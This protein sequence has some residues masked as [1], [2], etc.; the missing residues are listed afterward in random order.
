MDKRADLSLAGQ[1]GINTRLSKMTAEQRQ[2]MT[3]A[4]NAGWLARFERQ[5]DPDNTLDPEERRRRATYARHAYM[6]ALAKRSVAARQKA[7][8]HRLRQQLAELEAEA[9][10]DDGSAA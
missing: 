8:A 7:K 10:D 3:D 2:A 4:A 6:Q 5:V 9:G 1:I